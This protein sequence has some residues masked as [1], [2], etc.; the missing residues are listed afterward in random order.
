MLKTNSLKLIDHYLTTLVSLIEA[1][2]KIVDI[3]SEIKT[4][5][6]DRDKRSG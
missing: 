6:W 2:K 1:Q 3:K 4:E 5:L